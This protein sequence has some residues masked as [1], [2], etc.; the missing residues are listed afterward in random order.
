L[1][2]IV[3][4]EELPGV[5]LIR[6]RYKCNVCSKAEQEEWMNNGSCWSKCEVSTCPFHTMLQLLHKVICA[7]A[8][9]LNFL[10][11][12]ENCCR[13]SHCLQ[14][15]KNFAV[16]HNLNFCKTLG[17]RRCSGGLRCGHYVRETV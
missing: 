14:K 1:Q 13:I 2:Y 9:A 4:I 8:L 11:W 15:L 3:Y 6:S 12:I 17:S 16:K 7:V 10:K 5:F